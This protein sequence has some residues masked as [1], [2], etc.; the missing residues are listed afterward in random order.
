MFAPPS[1]PYPNDE[2][3]QVAR[4][5]QRMA[6]QDFE[7][8]LDLIQSGSLPT[9]R[10]QP[11]RAWILW[12]LGRE[13]ESIAAYQR[14]VEVPQ[15]AAVYASFG[16]LLL[17]QNREDEAEQQYQQALTI[18]PRQIEALVGM[19]TLAQRKEDF[20][21]SRDYALAALQRDDRQLTALLLLASADLQLSRLH[22]GLETC[23]R[24][25]RSTPPRSL[26]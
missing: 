12:Q 25:W 9:E 3:L 24:A 15:E 23:E 14:A 4:I 6:N 7:T 2:S 10:L 22:E 5:Q 1:T 8:A 13:E 17:Q 21:G 16:D 11:E 18:D 26:P 20:L 19:S